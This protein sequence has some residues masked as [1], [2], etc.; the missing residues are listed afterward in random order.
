MTKW[1]FLAVFLMLS[2]FSTGQAKAGACPSVQNADVMLNQ[3]SRLLEV[4]RRKA[5]RRA[6]TRDPLL[7]QAAQ[8]QACNV[9]ING[10]SARRPHHGPDGSTP[11]VRVKRTGYRTCLT[12]EN[13]ALGQRRPETLVNDWMGSPKHRTNILN[14]KLRQYGLAVA[15]AGGKPVWIM[16]L[17][18]PC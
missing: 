3:A 12:A 8:L 11:K 17:A 10:Y 16:V 18:R 13:L 2:P 9:A 6:I 7:D 14:R 4:A 1:I 15:N 5:G